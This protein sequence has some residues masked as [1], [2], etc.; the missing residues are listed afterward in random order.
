MLDKK[1]TACSTCQ[2]DRIKPRDRS[3]DNDHA[4]ARL[5]RYPGST[6]DCV[7]GLGNSEP[8]AMKLYLWERRVEVMQ[9]QVGGWRMILKWPD[10]RCSGPEAWLWHQSE[11]WCFN[12]IGNLHVWVHKCLWYSTRVCDK[13]YSIT[14][15]FKLNAEVICTLIIVDRITS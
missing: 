2:M 7:S 15:V 9:L 1:I 11:K 4:L 14:K 5:W 8:R 6:L 12:R 13:Q 3:S 10:E